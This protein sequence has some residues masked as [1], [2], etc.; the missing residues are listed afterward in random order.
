MPRISWKQKTTLEKNFK[1]QK[2]TCLIG[3]S[4]VIKCKEAEKTTFKVVLTYI[5]CNIANE[6]ATLKINSKEKYK[7]CQSFNSIFIFCITNATICKTGAIKTNAINKAT[8]TKYLIMKWI[9]MRYSLTLICV[10]WV[11]G[12]PS[13][14]LLATNF[15]QKIPESS[16]SIYCSILMLENI[17]SHYITWSG[18][19][20]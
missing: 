20:S 3:K 8:N 14:V 2:A 16:D 7:Y 4:T 17:L 10:K 18:P 5:S 12:D 19:N 13:T 15:I 11:P 9:V 1:I 6:T